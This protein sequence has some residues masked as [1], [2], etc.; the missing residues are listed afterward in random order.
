MHRQPPHTKI[1]ELRPK[2]LGGASESH[3][4][5]L[6]EVGLGQGATSSPGGSPSICQAPG[7]SKDIAHRR[8]GALTCGEACRQRL[9]RHSRDR[10]IKSAERKQAQQGGLQQRYDRNQRNQILQDFERRGLWWRD[11]TIDM[12]YAWQQA[13]DGYPAH[14]PIGTYPTQLPEKD[15]PKLRGLSQE[16]YD[17]LP[18]N[19][20]C[21]STALDH[22]NAK[23]HPEIFAPW[24]DCRYCGRAVLLD[25]LMQHHC[26][27]DPVFFDNVV[28]IHS[29]YKEVMAKVNAQLEERI[30]AIVHEDGE[31]TRRLLVGI[32]KAQNPVK[33]EDDEISVTKHT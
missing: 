11:Q 14:W 27:D 20:V 3:A 29:G 31:E 16:E 30:K 33:D 12:D 10:K 2:L 19:A 32:Y 1:S 7:C 18:S 25:K 5:Q 23:D 9:S 22:E 24:F 17:A 6:G 21:E 8:K 15:Q 13:T 4:T 26:L 28:D